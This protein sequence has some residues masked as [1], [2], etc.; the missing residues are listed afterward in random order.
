MGPQGKYGALFGH[1]SPGSLPVKDRRYMH[2]TSNATR[3]SQKSR[4]GLHC[5]TWRRE[6]RQPVQVTAR[7]EA[8]QPLRF[9]REAPVEETACS[10][11]GNETAARRSTGAAV[12]T[13][14]DVSVPRPRCGTVDIAECLRLRFLRPC[15]A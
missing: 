11:R 14:A 4:G 1:H 13:T 10:K 6:D 7:R 3:I 2:L 8:F 12:Q 15:S 5:A 9:N